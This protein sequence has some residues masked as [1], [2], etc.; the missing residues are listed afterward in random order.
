VPPYAAEPA[1]PAAEPQWQSGVQPQ[2]GP[3]LQRD[4]GACGAQPQAQ[5]APGH[6]RQV[7]A[8]AEAEADWLDD[9]LA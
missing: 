7:Q 1:A 2:F 4:A 3:Q 8:A 6:T 5:P 9:W